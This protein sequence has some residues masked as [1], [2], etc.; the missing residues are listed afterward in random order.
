MTK[1]LMDEVRDALR[2]KGYALG[3]ERQYMTWIRRYV[4]FHL[5]AHPRDVREEGVRKYLTYLAVE[6]NVSPTTQNQCLAALLFL[7]RL[8]GIDLG[9]VTA[10]RARKDKRVPAVLTEDEVMRLLEQLDGVYRIMAQ[11]MYGGGLRL[12]ECLRLRVKDLDLQNLTITLMDT[13]GN[14]DRVTCLPASVVP[15][16]TLHLAK[17]K[18]IHTEDLANGLGEVEMPHALGRKYPRAAWEWGWQYVFP[19]AQLSKDPRSDRVGR[20]HIFETSIQR[21]IKTAA[22]KAGIVK[23]CGPH[24]LRHCFATH[25]LKQGVNIR[26]IQEL[27]GHKKLETTMIYTHIEGASEVKSP[28]DRQLGTPFIRRALVES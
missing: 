4:R 20:H 27:L 12:M 11:I 26:Q 25:L 3:T 21:A 14:S 17:V 1:K 22:R 10:I 15:A 2:V 5:P 28:L 7:Y 6:C 8:L 13:K 18:A 19:A 23:P 24:T 9:D 16:L